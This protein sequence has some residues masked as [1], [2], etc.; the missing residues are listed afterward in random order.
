VTLKAQ[1]RKRDG[2][3]HAETIAK[4]SP[5]PLT[6]KGEEGSEKSGFK[7]NSNSEVG[8]RMV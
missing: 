1:R 7:V 5:E 4:N 3:P 8:T 6:V 2:G